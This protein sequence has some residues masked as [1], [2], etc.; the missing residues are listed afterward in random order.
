ML[1]RVGWHQGTHK[2]LDRAS[3]NWK[4]W[5]PAA[6]LQHYSARDA[7]SAQGLCLK[8]HLAAESVEGLSLDAQG[9]DVSAPGLDLKAD[10][11]PQASRV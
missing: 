2:N 10:R 4:P 9:E 5:Q 7:S 6:A 3:G 11:A 8:R 1:L